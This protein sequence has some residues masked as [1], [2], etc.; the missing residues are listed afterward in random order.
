MELILSLQRERGLGFLWITH[1]LG[2]AAEV[3]DRLLV[4]YGGEPMEAG[5]TATLL[6]AP[7]HPY[8]ARLLEAAR[9]QPS[10]EGGFLAA[11]QERGAGCPF[12]PRCLRAQTSCATWGPWQGTPLVGLRCERP[13]EPPLRP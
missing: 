11:P 8:T 13:L 4:L 12:R 9:R 7:G 5:P 10:N 2:V 1:D 3:C 6:A